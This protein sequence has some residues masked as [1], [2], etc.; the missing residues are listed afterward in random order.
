MN[1]FKFYAFLVLGAVVFLAA[2]A[3]TA[4]RA[5]AQS[6]LIIT[7]ACSTGLF[8]RYTDCDSGKSVS[9][10]AMQPGNARYAIAADGKSF[11]ITTTGG[12]GDYRVSAWTNDGKNNVQEL[13]SLGTFN[14][15]SRSFALSSEARNKGW[16][17]DGLTAYAPGRAPAEAN[18]NQSGPSSIQYPI[19]ELGGCTDQNNCKSFCER[20]E[21]MT[22]CVDFAEK[23]SLMKPE[24]L[25]LSK[26]V[27]ARVT[28]GTTPGGCT[29]KDSCEKFCQGNVDQINQCVSFAEELGVLSPEELAQAKKVTKALAGGGK[30]PG[31]CTGKATCESYCQD[32]SHIDECLDFAEKADMMP[33]SELA[34]ARK[35]AKFLK[36]GE[37]PGKCKTKDECQKYCE[38]DSHF[39]DCVGFAEKAGLVSKEDADMA[40]KVGGKGPGGCKNKESCDTYCNDPA[41]GDECFNFA[42]SKGLISQEEL[43]QIID[44]GMA[45]LKGGLDQIPPDARPE[46]EA[47]LKNVMG[48][49]AAYQDIMSGKKMPTKEMGSKMGPCF[50]DVMKNYAQ[51][52]MQKAGAGGAKG[53]G[54]GGIPHG[55]PPA[56]IP[57][58]FNPKDIQGSIPAGVP[59]SVKAQIQKQVEEGIKAG[60]AQAGGQAGP[61]VNIPQGGPPAGTTFGPPA[62]TPMGPPAGIPAGSGPPAGY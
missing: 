46:V 44:E 21:N 58:D 19:P 53:G 56:G 48:G 2:G 16:R 15:E 59:D 43:K 55:G 42:K 52:M 7:R 27:A 36:N 11:K 12:Q 41:H 57:K 18:Q 24:E 33:A 14:A 25:A 50:E 47:C 39:G 10:A 20:K 5:A 37:T 6:T 34:E 22:K 54:P 61:P 60:A 40:R 8:I 29:T 49:D 9:R 26:K 32:T 31:G 35:V 13:T 4:D 28:A 30:M 38:D 23:K 51:K 17:V 3:V 1:R 62:G 45:K